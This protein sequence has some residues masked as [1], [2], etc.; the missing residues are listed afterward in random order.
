MSPYAT[1]IT[2]FNIYFISPNFVINGFLF[3]QYQFSKSY[4]SHAVQYFIYSFLTIIIGF[5]SLFDILILITRWSSIIKKIINYI[6]QYSLQA[7]MQQQGL[8]NTLFVTGDSYY[9]KKIEN[10][11]KRHKLQIFH[12]KNWIYWAHDGVRLS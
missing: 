6:G 3:Q 2:I 5:D 7:S 9:K 12:F 10:I 4:L 1:F 11:V 8:L